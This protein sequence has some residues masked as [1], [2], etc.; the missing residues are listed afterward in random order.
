M[1]F[2]QVLGTWFEICL[3]RLFLSKII[4]KA[5]NYHSEYRNRTPYCKLFSCCR[6]KEYNIL[7]RTGS[8]SETCFPHL[9]HI[10]LSLL[11]HK[12]YFSYKRASGQYGGKYTGPESTQVQKLEPRWASFDP[13]IH[14]LYIYEAP[15]LGPE[16]V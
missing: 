14:S 16:L 4:S 3:V 9:C 8:H 11:C 7:P 1:H 5:R 6:S 15:I 10:A 13:F 12:S 2:R